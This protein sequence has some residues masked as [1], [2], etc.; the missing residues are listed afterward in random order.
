MQHW[1]TG[2]ASNELGN[3]GEI[4]MNKCSRNYRVYNVKKLDLYDSYVNMLR[5]S[6]GGKTWNL[7]YF[8][9]I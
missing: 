2:K 3:T 1:Q 6:D 4:N 8:P 9:Y 7:T 5:F